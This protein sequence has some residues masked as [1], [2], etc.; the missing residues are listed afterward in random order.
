MKTTNKMLLAMATPLITMGTLT[1]EDSQTEDTGSTK[2]DLERRIADLEE[3]AAMT[4]PG[5][6]SSLLTGFAYAGY[7]D[8]EG[9][10]SNFNTSF[11]PIFLWK[12]GD[13]LLFESELEITLNDS[14]TEVELGYAQMLLVVNDNLTIGVGKFLSPSNYFAERIHPS[15]INKLATGPLPFGHGGLM[16]NAQLGVQARGGFAIGSARA[17]YALYVS[18]G[19]TIETDGPHA[20]TLDFDNFSDINNNKAVGGRIGFRPVDGLEFGYGFEVADA[21]ASDSGFG[22]INTFTQ[23]VDVAYIRNVEFLKGRINARAQF[24]WLDIDNPNMGD[25][26]FTNKSDGGYT[27]VAYRPT[28]AEHEILND[29]EAVVRYDWINQ[30]MENADRLSLGLNY[31]LNDST[32]LKCSYE[33]KTEEEDGETIDSTGIRIQ[34]A[35]GF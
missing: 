17:S 15:W 12:K 10:H 5:S 32:V 1:A 28:E 6:S 4:R 27:Q 23:S 2:A 26:D 18:T 8:I 11:S 19:P 31:W 25:L 22:S 33:W 29:F 21:S 13:N 16:A 7:G 14:E 30:P 3:V 20:G 35:I 24:V 9:E 34:V